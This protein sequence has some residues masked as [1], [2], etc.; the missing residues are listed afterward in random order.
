MLTNLGFHVQAQ[1]LCFEDR[2][3]A[4]PTLCQVWVSK[5]FQEKSQK[6]EIMGPSLQNIPL[7]RC[8]YLYGSMNGKSSHTIFS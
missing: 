6:K 1:L 8:I 3:N 7:G 5:E 2:T 4:Y